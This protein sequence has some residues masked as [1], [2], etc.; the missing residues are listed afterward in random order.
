[1]IELVYNT[2]V[3][4]PA[5]KRFYSAGP[6]QGHLTVPV[7]NIYVS[8]T[9]SEQKKMVPIKVSFPDKEEKIYAR[10]QI[11][12]LDYETHFRTRCYRISALVSYNGGVVFI[13]LHIS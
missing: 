13:R 10:A 4:L 2:T 1:M 3:L 7:S 5:V 6:T 9:F 11:N 12:F 8:V